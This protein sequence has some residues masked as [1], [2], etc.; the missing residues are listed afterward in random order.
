MHPHQHLYHRL[1][2]RYLDA[3]LF[4]LTNLQERDSAQSKKDLEKAQTRI[5]EEKEASAKKVALV[6]AAQTKAE[7]EL[8]KTR[9]ELNDITNKLRSADQKHELEMKQ[10]TSQ[11]DT[12]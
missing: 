7:E 3:S 1:C 11:Y 6:T 5:T 8:S 2:W 9:A 12:L 10:V 4:S